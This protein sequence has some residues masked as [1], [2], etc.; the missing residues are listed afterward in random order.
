[1]RKSEARMIP[2]KGKA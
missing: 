2:W 1:M